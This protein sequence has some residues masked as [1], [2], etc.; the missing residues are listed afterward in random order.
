MKEVTF[1]LPVFNKEKI[2]RLILK[3]ISDTYPD[4]K[5]IVIDN[6]SIDKTA[7]IAKDSNALVLH[8]EKHGKYHAVKKGF[9]Y[10][11]TQCAVLL[12]AEEIHNPEEIKK[13][14]K[15]LFNNKKEIAL[16]SKSNKKM[17][18]ITKFDMINYHLFQLI[19]SLLYYNTSDVFEGYWAFK[20]EFIEYF[21]QK[22]VKSKGFEGEAE[23]FSVISKGHFKIV[24][25]PVKYAADHP[26]KLKT[27]N[28]GL[29]IYKT[30]SG[31]IKPH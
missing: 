8:E 23:M 25:V 12:E 14:I 30:I 6:N 22:D 9:K 27:S 29:K 31:L 4:S 19:S 2:I 11:K 15:S 26:I 7:Q 20:K 16:G 10:V 18:S 24:E 21:I 17:I 13:L 5:I 3:K 28:D 1:I